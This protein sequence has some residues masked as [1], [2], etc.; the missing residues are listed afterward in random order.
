[1]QCDN[2]QGEDL[3]NNSKRTLAAV[4]FGRILSDGE[5]TLLRQNGDIFELIP[6]SLMEIIYLMDSDARRLPSCRYRLSGSSLHQSLTIEKNRAKFKNV[7]ILFFT[8][9]A[10]LANI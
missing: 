10:L 9:T 8:S 3:V 4:I 7:H 5:W 2:T 6:A 1:M